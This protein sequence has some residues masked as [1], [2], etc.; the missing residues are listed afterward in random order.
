[1]CRT[2]PG[3]V[4]IVPRSLARAK[5]SSPD[6]EVEE[7][8]T[9]S[10]LDDMKLYDYALQTKRRAGRQMSKGADETFQLPRLSVS[11]AHSIGC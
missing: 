1:V 7:H 3:V 5:L 11:E 4:V 2:D 6:C 10:S 8:G 9:V